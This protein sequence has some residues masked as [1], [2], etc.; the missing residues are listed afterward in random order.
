MV[1]L[2]FPFSVFRGIYRHPPTPPGMP[3]YG[4]KLRAHGARTSTRA[5]TSLGILPR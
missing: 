2:P 1:V 3:S 4:R 5:S